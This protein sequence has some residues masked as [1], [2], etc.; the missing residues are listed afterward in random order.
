MDDF[1]LMLVALFFVG[2]IFLFPFWMKNDLE[3]HINKHRDITKLSE[4]EQL[5]IY[6]YYRN[7]VIEQNIKNLDEIVN[8][9]P[10]PLPQVMVELQKMIDENYLPNYH[11]D[12]T[13]NTL[14]PKK[15]P[16]IEIEW[17]KREL[18]TFYATIPDYAIFKSNDQ[19]YQTYEIYKDL[20]RNQNVTSIDI[21]AS[22]VDKPLYTVML[23]IQKM[24]D[25]KYIL[26]IHINEK[27]R[28]IEPSDGPSIDIS[29]TIKKLFANEIICPN[30]GA[31]SVIGKDTCDYC[32]TRF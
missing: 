24:I 6:N 3:K 2:G 20:I 27:Y 21:I 17:Y 30:C 5:L 22:Q 31:I 4:N 19:K 9:F 12:I 23:E 1:S 15:G 32:G 18:E 16:K 25:E 10:R 28:T 8:I 7:I 13:S 29:A 14:I 26:D 11:I